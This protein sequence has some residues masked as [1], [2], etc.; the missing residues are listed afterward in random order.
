MENATVS[1]GPR[2]RA[3]GQSLFKAGM[4]AQGASGHQDTMQP[5]LRCVPISDSKYP[6]LLD[7]DWVAGN[8]TVIGDVKLGEG[9]SLWHGVIVRG[10]TAAVQIGK[11][12]VV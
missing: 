8:A 3:W 10:D 2:F 11:N 5:S 9:A 12:S 6:K 7:S 1:M 4:A